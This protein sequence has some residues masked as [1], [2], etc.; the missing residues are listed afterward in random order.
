MQ[1]ECEEIKTFDE[2]V[3]NSG[4]LKVPTVLFQREIVLNIDI[5]EAKLQCCINTSLKF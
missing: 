4:I 3:Q 1:F 5:F 2:V